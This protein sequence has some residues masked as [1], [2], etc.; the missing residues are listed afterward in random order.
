M[1]L[2]LL[3]VEEGV[4]LQNNFRVLIYMLIFLDFFWFFVPSGWSYL[5]HDMA[6]GWNGEGGIIA[7]RVYDIIAYSFFVLNIFTYLAL[8]NFKRW[9]P[10]LFLILI[11]IDLV[12]TPFYG[13]NVFSGFE[14]LLHKL[15]LFGAAILLSMIYFSDLKRDFVR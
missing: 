6:Q 4:V 2:L 5:G 8:Y 13:V 14:T 7:G 15:A 3:E 12:L 10:K 11:F 9:A 1:L